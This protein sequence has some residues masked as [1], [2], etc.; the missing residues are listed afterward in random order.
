MV[1]VKVVIGQV[2]E[3]EQ[4]VVG[5]DVKVFLEDLK[6]VGWV[7]SFLVNGCDVVEEVKELVMLLM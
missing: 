7:R 6:L 5:V 3:E 4:Q 2:E 1:V